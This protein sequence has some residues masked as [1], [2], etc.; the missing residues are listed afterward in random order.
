MAEK[1]GLLAL[2]ARKGHKHF[3][4]VFLPYRFCIKGMFMGYLYP[5][6]T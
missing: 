2:G 6:F 1:K 5:S 3:G 4:G